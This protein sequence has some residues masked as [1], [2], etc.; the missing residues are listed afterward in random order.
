[1]DEMYPHD[2]KAWDEADIRLCEQS[3]FL[4][5]QHWN[6]VQALAQALLAKPVTVRPAESFKKWASPDTHEQWI[7][8]NQ[9]AAILRKF[10]L[11]A[12]VRKESEG[13]YYAPDIHTRS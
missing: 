6:V 2:K 12:D 9:I 8:G 13:T 1:M 10:Q 4:V 7:D 11:S 3:R 5:N